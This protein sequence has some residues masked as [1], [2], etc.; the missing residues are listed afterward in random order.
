MHADRCMPLERVGV[1]SWKGSPLEQSGA[2]DKM[3]VIKQKTSPGTQSCLLVHPAYDSFHHFFRIS[4]YFEIIGKLCN[5]HRNNKA[6]L[7]I[8]HLDTE[9][10]I[11][12]WIILEYMAN[13]MVL[14]VLKFNMYYLITGHSPVNHCTLIKFRKFNTN[15]IEW[16]IIQP[17]F[18]FYILL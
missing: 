10:S 2:T 3:K 8:L 7:H 18:K 6:F 14:Y 15:V 17:I 9:K 1:N 12:F 5:S 16:F 13:I 4:F 11:F